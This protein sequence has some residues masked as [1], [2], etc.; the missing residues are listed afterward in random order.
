MPLAMA[1]AGKELY[2]KKIGGREEVRQ[3][4]AQL[5]FVVGGMVKVISVI[6]G[7]IIVQVKES[8]IAVSREMAMKIIV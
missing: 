7:N 6:G 4:L 8:R 5:G 1:E 3:H 2:I